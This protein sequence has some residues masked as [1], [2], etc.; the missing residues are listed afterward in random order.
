VR[1]RRIPSFREYLLVAQKR[2]SVEQYVRTPDERTTWV[3]TEY[4]SLEDTIELVTI[5]V[6]LRLKDIYNKINFPV[7]VAARRKK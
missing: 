3:M 2:V 5:P 4:I 1:Y 6:R 7:R